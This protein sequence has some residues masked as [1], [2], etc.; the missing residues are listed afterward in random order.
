METEILCCLNS[1]S[2]P[3]GVLG[4][5]QGGKAFLCDWAGEK[6]KRDFFTRILPP[7]GM[8]SSHKS[9]RAQCQ[10]YSINP[11]Q[12]PLWGSVEAERYYYQVCM[13]FLAEF[14]IRLSLSSASLSFWGS[15]RQV[16]A[17]PLAPCEGAGLPY[18]PLAHQS[19]FYSG[20]L[21]T[22]STS[23]CQGI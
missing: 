19:T 6:R 2:L 12:S 7:S 22:S 13:F 23:Y 21:T 10:L 14:Y 3:S 8:N 4:Q 17:R 20:S 18:F 1:G 15:S 16:L 11:A 9:C 5:G